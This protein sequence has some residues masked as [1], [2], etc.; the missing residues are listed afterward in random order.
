MLQVNYDSLN[1]QNFLGIV[2][3]IIGSILMILTLLIFLG[4]EIGIAT[5][6]GIISL[7]L[8]GIG[9][10]KRNLFK[11]ADQYIVMINGGCLDLEEISK[12]RNKNLKDVEE[13]I[14]A[15][16]KNGIFINIYYDKEENKIKEILYEKS[17]KND[18]IIK[19]DK[20]PGCGAQVDINKSKFCEFCGRKLI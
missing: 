6:F 8:L 2:Y 5:F 3:I 14:E 20:C 9:F 10:F 11:S 7:V 19:I 18:Q 17:S 12:K 4:E 1:K 13:E 15:F 16:I